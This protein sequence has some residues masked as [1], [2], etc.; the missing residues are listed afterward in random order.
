MAVTRRRLT[1]IRCTAAA[2]AVGGLEL[3]ETQGRGVGAPWFLYTL[4][5]VSRTAAYA[6]A[7]DV[8]LLNVTNVSYDGFCVDK[9]QYR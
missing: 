3:L 2:A 4:G 8:E 6:G 1:P 5:S 9:P 7:S